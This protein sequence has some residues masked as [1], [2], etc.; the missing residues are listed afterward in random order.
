MGGVVLSLVAILGALMASSGGEEGSGG[1]FPQIGDHWHA[2]YSITLCGETEPP[3]PISEGGVHTH[4]SG[5][6]HLHPTHNGE[7]GRNANLARFIA[8]TGSRLTDESIEL[9]SG[10]KYTNGDPCPD[11]EAGQVFLQVNGI[12]MTGIASY[13]PRDGDDIE[14]GFEAQ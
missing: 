12:A 11:G 8:S 3:F 1:R 10:V 6:I 2:D 13:V 7:A 5:V 4:G 14:M 9:L